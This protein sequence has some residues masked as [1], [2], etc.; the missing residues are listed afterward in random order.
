M[1]SSYSKLRYRFNA[2]SQSRAENS[3]VRGAIFLRMLRDEQ[4]Y[5]H[6]I[7][8]KL[9]VQGARTYVRVRGAI[10]LYECFETS[11]LTRTR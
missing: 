10:F 2:T 3:R 5:S 9:R 1:A 11:K 8:V 6:S 4:I 7:V